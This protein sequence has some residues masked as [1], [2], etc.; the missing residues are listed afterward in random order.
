MDRTFDRHRNLRTLPP[1]NLSAWHTAENGLS[2]VHIQTFPIM[3][4]STEA[5][6]KTSRSQV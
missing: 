2:T 6:D 4:D 3:S 5:R 1:I